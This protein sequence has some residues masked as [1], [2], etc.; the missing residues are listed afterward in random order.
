MFFCYVNDL[1]R[2]VKSCIKLYGDDVIP[3]VHNREVIL[4]RV[5]DNAADHQQDL[6]ALSEWANTWQM[7][8]N[9]FKC[10]LLRITN[11]KNLSEYCYTT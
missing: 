4:Y 5:I 3:R 11:K 7:T 6:V 2:P 10:E 9:L 8:F 1:P